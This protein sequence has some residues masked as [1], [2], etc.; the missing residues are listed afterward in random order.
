MAGGL[1][2]LGA[3]FVEIFADKSKMDTTLREARADVEQST[4]EIG[5][6]FKRNVGGSIEESIKPV[7][8]FRET[9][10]SIVAVIGS[11][12]AAFAGLARSVIEL[13][14]HALGV[15]ESF[16]KSLD[17]IRG[18]QDETRTLGEQIAGVYDEQ[19]NKID[20]LRVKIVELGSDTIK[21][22]RE[23]AGALAKIVNTNLIDPTST[24]LG[25]NVLKVV[26]ETV[27]GMSELTGVGQGF[28]KD[29]GAAA[30]SQIDTIDRLVKQL[31][32]DLA[33]K[34]DAYD[35]EK[36]K[37]DAEARARQWD[38]MEREHRA[39]MDAI[40]KEHEQALRLQSEYYSRLR[41]QFTDLGG[42]RAL[43]ELPGIIKRLGSKI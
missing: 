24:S 20:Q 27:K 8:R 42:L 26:G 43:R 9:L 23:T 32:K 30:Q 15:N 6:S 13:S 3:A 29:M 7:K 16:S 28:Y 1:R 37:R 21:Q 38:Q 40:E 25:D 35:A 34:Q 11:L 19:A 14:K 36:R 17:T 31:L 2:K 18:L 12:V 22:Q 41:S 10:L 4:Q 39:R 33:D 5:G